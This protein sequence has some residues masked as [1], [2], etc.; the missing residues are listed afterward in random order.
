MAGLFFLEIDCKEMAAE[1][2]F[3]YFVLMADL[4]YKPA[5][6]LTLPTKLWKTYGLLN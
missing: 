1:I 5:N 6:K 2:F 4:G 3:A